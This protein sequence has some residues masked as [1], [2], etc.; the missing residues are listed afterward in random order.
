[1]AVAIRRRATLAAV[2][3]NNGVYTLAECLNAAEPISPA[4]GNVVSSMAGGNLKLE[5][6]ENWRVTICR[7]TAY[8]PPASA[9]PHAMRRKS[10][11][12]LSGASFTRASSP[13]T[14]TMT[15][16]QG[17]CSQHHVRELVVFLASLSIMRTIISQKSTSPGRLTIIRAI[18]LF[19][20]PPS[21]SP[22]PSSAL[23]PSPL[24]Q[25]N[26]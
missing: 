17:S 24:S 5:R 9:G 14:V 11:G 2:V 19:S 10:I 1:V 25:D 15:H 16:S 26:A 18:A 23:F 4:D 12:T 3:I 6:G 22:V 21:V 8:I 20:C 13:L 7:S